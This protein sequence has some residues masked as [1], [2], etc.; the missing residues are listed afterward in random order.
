[1]IN[2]E[3][4]HKEFKKWLYIKDTGRIDAMLATA[5]ATTQTGEPLWLLNIGTSGYAKSEIART[6][7]PW[8]RSYHL[9]NLTTNALC[10]GMSNVEDLAPKLKNKLILIPESAQ[11]M[12][13]HPDQKRMLWAQ[14]RTL[15]DGDM[16]KVTGIGVEKEYH[17]L[18]CGLYM[19]GT[20]IIDRQILIHQD[21]GTRELIYR[22]TV[23]DQ[24]INPILNK[25]IT[26]RHKKAQLREKLSK[27][28]VAFMEKAKIK[29]IEPDKPT[30]ED[31]K[32]KARWLAKM[33][34]T[35]ATDNVTGETLEQPYPE[36][37]AR[38]VQQFTRYYTILM[39]IGCSHEE[40]MQIINHIVESSSIPMRTMVYRVVGD[41]GG[42]ITTRKIADTL[43]V[44]HKTANRECFALWGLK[45]FDKRTE[46]QEHRF[47]TYW[48]VPDPQQKIEAPQRGEAID[49]DY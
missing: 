46:K 5:L 31:L 47:V 41:N 34:T 37:P 48:H 19:C 11:L 32:K 10:S 18:Y 27:K 1:M 39:S 17:D 9:T 4:V 42:E 22:S 38:L 23:E 45:F 40:T 44:G 36:L 21:L 30:T 25:A 49:D 8:E 6:L 12:A 7:I 14:L 26:N 43:R 20:Q 24:E 2:L 35:I 29:D 33:R 16:G 28:V 15:Y 13:M 3:Q